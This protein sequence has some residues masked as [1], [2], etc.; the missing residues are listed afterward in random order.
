MFGLWGVART[1]SPTRFDALINEMKIQCPAGIEYLNKEHNN[2]WSRSKFGT[3]AKY[4]SLTNN[5]S[6]TFNAWIS[7]ERYKPVID[8]LDL[9]RQKIIMKFDRRRRITSTW[10][11]TLVPKVADY[12]KNISRVCYLA[13]ISIFF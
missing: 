5:F 2:L 1:Y 3:V 7:D 6:E 12:V 4:D 10:K 11:G 13:F 8:V 9:I